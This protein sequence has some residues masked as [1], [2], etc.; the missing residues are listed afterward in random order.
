MVFKQVNIA[1]LCHLLNTGM[2]D[3]LNIKCL[4][5]CTICDFF[6]YSDME[7]VYNFLYFLWL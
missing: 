6:M 1:D 4:G 3:L 7:M 5:E 2:P